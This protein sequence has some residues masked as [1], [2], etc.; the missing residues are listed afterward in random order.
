MR[1]ILAAL[2]LLAGAAAHAGVTVRDGLVTADLQAEP[3]QNVVKVIGQE[4]GVEIVIDSECNNEM[5]YAKFEN[6]PIGAAIRKLL[7][8]TEIN[9]AVVAAPD[10]SAT[11]IMI[12][13]SQGQSAPPKKLDTRPVTASPNRG[14]VTP[15]TP[16]PPV[17][18]QNNPA[19][20][21]RIQQLQQ[22][23]EQH[24]QEKEALQKPA[25]PSNSVP[26]AGSFNPA[27]APPPAQPR[28]DP[29]QETGEVMPNDEEEEE[30]DEE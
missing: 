24:R 6:L 1:I 22:Q 8:G 26:T 25:N 21:D 3:L 15:V 10:G 19:R 11:T 5:V 16:P 9:F 28:L 13:R 23:Q 12:A 14:V 4:S 30:D 18:Q 20:N 27:A 7:E 2:L 29:K 17:P